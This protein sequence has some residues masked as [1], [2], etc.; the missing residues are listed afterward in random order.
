[1]SAHNVVGIEHGAAEKLDRFWNELSPE[2]KAAL[3]IA[4]NDR[5]KSFGGA[6]KTPF[7]FL[8]NAESGRNG[9]NSVVNRFLLFMEAR[10]NTCNTAELMME[11]IFAWGRLNKEDQ[12]HRFFHHS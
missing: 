12:D 9:I 3:H 7:T 5:D 8:A 11:A 1:M 6:Y 4:F 2:H 10:I